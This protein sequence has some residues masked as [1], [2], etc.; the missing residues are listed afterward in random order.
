MPLLVLLLEPPMP[1]ALLEAV[2]PPAPLVVPPDCMWTLSE[3]HEL[4]SAPAAVSPRSRATAVR[5]TEP[6]W[7]R[8]GSPQLGHITSVLLAW[9]LQRGQG[10]RAEAMAESSRSGPR[11]SSLVAYPSGMAEARGSPRE[12]R[13]GDE[14][15]PRPIFAVW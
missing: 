13:P 4:A 9:Q 11:R 1:L 6:S 15:A 2:A 14:D 7:R 3:P 8:R 12:Q 10:T 5:G